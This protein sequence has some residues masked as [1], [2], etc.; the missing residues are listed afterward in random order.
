MKPGSSGCR[1][2]SFELISPLFALSS[3]FAISAEQA[4][5]GGTNPI[6]QQKT[7]QR[8]LPGFF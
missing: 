8:E 4:K 7:R 5:G 3:I 2:F 1:V 6:E